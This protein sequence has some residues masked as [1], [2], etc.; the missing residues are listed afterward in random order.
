MTEVILAVAL[1]F[2]G[3]SLSGFP[4]LLFVD[5]R[6][7]GVQILTEVLSPAE[8]RKLRVRAQPGRRV[9][10]AWVAGTEPALNLRIH[11][12]GQG[13]L[14]LDSGR[15]LYRYD[16]AEP[17]VFKLFSGEGLRFVS[18]AAYV[19]NGYTLSYRSE[20]QSLSLSFSGREE[21]W[22]REGLYQGPAGSFEFTVLTP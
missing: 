22:L 18:Q 16:E 14:V 9:E 7:Q 21:A 6:G 17:G 20:N 12:D 15:Y 13:L 3:G 11:W 2:F 8:D 10:G 5:A 4:E 19:S 1:T